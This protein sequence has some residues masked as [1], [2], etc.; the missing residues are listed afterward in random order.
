MSWELVNL[1]APFAHGLSPVD[2]GLTRAVV[3]SLFSD[4]RALADD[5]LPDGSTSRRG[6]WADS[7]LPPH[8]APAVSVWNT[9]S[10]LWLLA[11]EKQTPETL[12]RAK[13]YAEEALQWLLQRKDAISVTVDASWKAQGIL[14][15]LVQIRLTDGT[16]WAHTFSLQQQQ[17]GEAYAVES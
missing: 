17:R 11:R 4:A 5:A 14:S 3:I 16:L 1:P 13:A 2:D 15:L 9:G 7:V 10:R 12:R 8:S 6:F